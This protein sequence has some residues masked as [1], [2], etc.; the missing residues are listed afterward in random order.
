MR[1]IRFAHVCRH[2]VEETQGPMGRRVR[3]E[4]FGAGTILDIDKT[5][6]THIIQFEGMETP[7]A[8]S[9]RAKLEPLDDGEEK[10]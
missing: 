2:A 3:H 7:R 4:I 1:N 6:R 10:L 8:I 5:K 9:F